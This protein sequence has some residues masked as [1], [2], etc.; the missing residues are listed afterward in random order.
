MVA[1]KTFAWTE[2][3]LGILLVIIN[4]LW[5]FVLPEA[6]PL[7]LYAITVTLSILVIIVGASALATKPS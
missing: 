1:T 7:Y 3:A 2:I 5:C 4:L 6:D